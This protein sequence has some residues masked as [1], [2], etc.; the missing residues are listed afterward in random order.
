MDAT[1]ANPACASFDSWLGGGEGIPAPE[2]TPADA[3]LGSDHPEQTSHRSI[4]AGFKGSPQ[5]VLLS[6]VLPPAVQTARYHECYMMRNFCMRLP[7]TAGL[8]AVKER[9]RLQ[10]VR[11]G[12]FE[13][14]VATWRLILVNL[15]A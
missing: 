12:R 8:A 4:Q 5:S 3:L 10:L 13:L 7:V 1:C 9:L 2:D 6:S 11:G 14:H 15:L